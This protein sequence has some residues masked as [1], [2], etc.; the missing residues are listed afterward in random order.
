MDHL[1]DLSVDAKAIQQWTLEKQTVEI[2]NGLMWVSIG[3]NGDL[4]TDNDTF[5]GSTK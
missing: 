5:T 2:Q 1:Q 4:G 3:S